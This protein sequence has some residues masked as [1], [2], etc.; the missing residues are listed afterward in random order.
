MCSDLVGSE[1]RLEFNDAN[2]VLVYLAQRF[3]LSKKSI[4]RFL[5]QRRF[6]TLNPSQSNKQ[7]DVNQKRDYNNQHIFY[8]GVHGSS[9]KGFSIHCLN[10]SWIS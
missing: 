6:E 3:A 1:E 9:Y 4:E 5:A 8:V 10:K 7:W 2:E